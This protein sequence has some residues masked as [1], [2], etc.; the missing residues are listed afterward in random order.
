MKPLILFGSLLITQLLL[1]FVCVYDR[2]AAEME[3]LATTLV[4]ALFLALHFYGQRWARWVASVLLGLMTLIAG[5]MTLEGFSGGFLGIACLYAVIIVMLFRA[6]LSQKDAEDVASTPRDATQNL[7]P[8]AN[9]FYVGEK[10]YRYPLLVKRYQSVFI[11][12]ILW[13]FVMI[14]T[15]VIMGESEW[16]PVVMLTLWLSAGFLYEPLLTRY[17][18]TIG[19]RIIGIR[20]RKVSN[21]D[22]RISLFDAYA[23]VLVKWF[24][25]WL[26]FLTI[27]SNAQHRAIHDMAGSSVVVKTSPRE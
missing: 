22:E 7:P 26:S 25:G 5:S 15:M 27:H 10:V 21:P 17:S 14:V 9:G 1:Y 24:L 16:R 23:R 6:R 4:I 2:I 11:D 19:Q 8:V 20:V 12:F 13:L 3:V 18:A